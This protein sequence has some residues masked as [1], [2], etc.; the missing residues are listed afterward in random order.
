VLADSAKASDVNAIK[1]GILSD[2]RQSLA[3]HKVPAMIS[4]VPSLDITGA[5]KLARQ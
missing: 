2:C 3:S 5:G 4:F 1:S